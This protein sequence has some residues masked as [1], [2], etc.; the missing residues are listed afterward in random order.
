M[1]LKCCL[2]EDQSKLSVQWSTA[3]VACQKMPQGQV[4][5]WKAIK[6]EYQSFLCVG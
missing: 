5:L 6:L 1:A 4:A 2:T 3:V